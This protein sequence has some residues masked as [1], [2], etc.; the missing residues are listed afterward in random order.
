MIVKCPIFCNCFVYSIFPYAI[1]KVGV[2]EFWR[3]NQDT[4][5]CPI[6]SME[7]LQYECS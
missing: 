2:K 6:A 5:K 1:Y 4:L 3:N 7:W